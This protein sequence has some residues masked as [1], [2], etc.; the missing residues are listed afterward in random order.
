MDYRHRL[1]QIRDFL[2]PY[3]EMWQNEIMLMYP[4]PLK[5]YPMEWI[6]ELR[7]IKDKNDIIKLEKKEVEGL[8][9]EPTLLEFYTRIQELTTLDA[10]P[11][12]PQLKEDAHTWTFMTVKKQHEIK[13][14]V[15]HVHAV[16]QKL[17][18]PGIIDIGG[19][20]G[21]LAQSLHNHFSLKVTSIDM[22]PTLQETG[23]K[24][25]GKEKVEYKNLKVEP[26]S[27]F[28]NLL[29][30]KTMTVGLHTCGRLALDIIRES[31]NKKVPALINFGC[32][33][34][35]LFQAEDLQN[36]SSFAQEHG[37]LWMDK[38]AL[39][40]S[41]RA[42]NKMPE[43][44]YDLKLKVKF[45]RYAIH[46]LLHDHYGLKELVTLG[47]SSPRLYDEPFGH[48]ALEQLQRIKLTSKHTLEELNAFFHNPELQILIE[49]MLMAGLIRNA[50][51]RVL[52]LYLLLDR[53]IYLE[54]R[55]YKVR[56][57]EFFD[58]ELSPRNIGITAELV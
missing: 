45:Y 39:T 15:P 5:G 36:I 23:K 21:L 20:I 51:G 28:S 13:R 31:S 25:Y 33:Y 50:L 1:I 43:K 3:Q 8:V 17:N 42:H 30:T 4:E 16:A 57:E 35:N 40:L 49:R 53:A 41:C 12:Y 54:E 32:C 38:F 14:V 7:S 26:N 46:I 44:E 52:E 58:E 22:N 34:H 11:V 9:K 24:R 55:G 47:N 27:E 29:S 19:G 37:K 18:I 6:E 56:L 2:K 48:Y 10:A